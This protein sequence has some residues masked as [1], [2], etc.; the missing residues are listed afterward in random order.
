MFGRLFSSLATVA[1][2]FREFIT[3]QVTRLWA[4][5]RRATSLTTQAAKA[6]PKALSAVAATSTKPSKRSDYVETKRLFI[7]KKFIVI[8]LLVL[9]ALALLIYFVVWPWLV[10]TFF[11]RKMPQSDERVADYNGKVEIYYDEAL[12]HLKFKGALSEG[13]MTGDGQ[14]YQEQGLPIYLGDFEKD[15]YDGTG[16]LYNASGM[17]IYEGQFADNLREGNGTEYNG[18]EQV[19]YVGQFVADERSGMGREYDN[20]VLVFEGEYKAGQRDGAGQEFDKDGN[21]IF[22]GEYKAGRRKGE[23]TE[24]YPNGKVKYKGEF[25][26]DLYSEQGVLYLEDGQEQYSGGF[27]EGVFSGEGTLHLSKDEWKTGEFSD[28]EISGPMAWYKAGKL[29]YEGDA[30]DSRPDGHGNLY[31][32]RGKVVFTGAF[33]AGEIDAHALLGLSAGDIR[34]C[35]ADAAYTESMDEYGFTIENS[36][37]GLAVY[38]SFSTAD[39]GAAVRKVYRVE[40]GEYTL[41]AEESGYEFVAKDDI[42]GL[43]DEEEVTAADDK[44]GAVNDKSGTVLDD[45]SGNAAQNQNDTTSS[46]E[47]GTTLNVVDPVQL[48]LD[49]EQS[50]VTCAA[51]KDTLVVLEQQL[52]LRKQQ[53]EILTQSYLLGLSDDKAMSGMQTQVDKL[54][55]EKQKAQ[56]TIDRSIASI[57]KTTALELYGLETFDFSQTYLQVNPAAIDQV[58]LLE[59]MLLYMPDKSPEEVEE[60]LEESIYTLELLYA[61]VTLAGKTVEA[62]AA[63]VAGWKD[64]FATGKITFSEYC[65]SMCEYYQAQMELYSAMEALSKEL[66]QLNADS[67]RALYPDTVASELLREA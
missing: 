64:D 29:Y 12:E 63:G 33:A 28:G 25:L 41:L 48:Y 32:A 11:V 24:Y 47:A 16:R 44:S 6:M 3:R 57:R 49:V 23:G 51:M 4:A 45:K 14:L 8:G 26:A 36:Q 40:D 15:A 18:A 56:L 27:A 31:N 59:A 21:L 1:R 20:G 65:D 55:T 54:E 5:F 66:Y 17:L 46:A 61:D 53:L 60:Q 22:E 7:A 50:M 42:V 39:S 13:K 52:S 38:C 19:V 35:F 34:T 43:A 67:G 62:L 9:I 2:M 30:I 58:Q 10:S 37:I